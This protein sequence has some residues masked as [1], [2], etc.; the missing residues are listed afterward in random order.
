M[1]AP[2]ALSHSDIATKPVILLPQWN[3]IP[4]G[5]WVLV[6]GQ[7]EQATALS[8]IHPEGQEW[9]IR[10][11]LGEPIAAYVNFAPR[12]KEGDRVAVLGR[13]LGSLHMADRQGVMRDYPA[14]IARTIDPVWVREVAAR[15][16]GGGGAAGTQGSA[17]GN[18][19]WFAVLAVV[20]IGGWIAARV[21]LRRSPGGSMSRIHG[22]A[23][24]AR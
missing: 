16:D 5:S 6:Q 10:T 24:R 9:F 12:V 23:E 20:L 8:P 21:F 4:E 7:L 14:V 18:A 1:G 11:A 19:G 13:A 15:L 17:V 3:S 22:V 2:G